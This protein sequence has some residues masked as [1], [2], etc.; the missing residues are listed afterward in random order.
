VKPIIKILSE[1]KL[2]GKRM[3]MSLTDNRTA[4]LWKSFMLKRNI[5]KNNMGSDLYSVQ[6]YEDSYFSDFDPN[7]EFEKWA[8]IEVEDLDTIP[9]G[10]H[11]LILVSG[12]YAV[13]LHKGAASTGA[14]TFQHIFGTWLPNSE[15][16]LDN[17]PHFEILGEKYKNDDPTSEEEIWIPIKVKLQV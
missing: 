1:K 16:E 11:A 13:F 10:M 6:V 3:T 4:E 9:D 2:I 7:A 14:K 15:Y 5:I 8:T 17:R 12:L